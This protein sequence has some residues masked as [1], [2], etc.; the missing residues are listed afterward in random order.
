[1][2][3]GS[4]YLQKPRIYPKTPKITNMDI[5]DLVNY[6]ANSEAYNGGR[7]VEACKVYENM[8]KEDAT[9]CLTLSGA[10][11]PTGLGGFINQLIKKG[12]ID[13]IISTGANLYH[14]L[15][16]ALDLPIYQ[17]D[18]RAD[19]TDLLKNGIVRIYDI[20]LPKETLLKT[21]E[22][23]QK[24][25]KGFLPDG[26]VSTACLHNYLGKQLLIKG[27]K[28]DY[29]IIATATKY[30]VPI[31][32]PSPGDSS[33]GMN[34]A[35][36]KMSNNDVVIDT[37]LDVLESTAIVFN[38]KKTGAVELGGGAPKNF[39]MQTQ[40]MLSQLINID[41]G[42]HDYFIQITADAPHWGGL[43][44]ATPSEAISWKKIKSNKL[45]NNVVVYCDVTIAAPL[46]F[47]FI[48]LKKYS[49]RLK[50]LYRKRAAFLDKL[51]YAYIKE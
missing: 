49:R 19:D 13:F 15:H 36:L 41:R 34:L 6:Y 2:K 29:S 11:T 8:I 5:L 3:K 43:S 14:D 1:M 46:L 22:F 51:K 18:F 35:L 33:I 26:T 31:F 24:V 50:R 42:G 44:G 20:F 30:D 17:G 4:S 7:L 21:D 37:D 28:P 32:T 40:P 48:L 39:Y 10:L 23:V 25:V 45:K 47:S 16:F 9:I 12:L 27:K 38:S